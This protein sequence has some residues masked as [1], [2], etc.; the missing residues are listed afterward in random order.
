MKGV[1][2]NGVKVGGSPSHG[3][4]AIQERSWY[5]VAKAVFLDGAALWPIR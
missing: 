2:E 4:I 5:Q 3:L 1:L